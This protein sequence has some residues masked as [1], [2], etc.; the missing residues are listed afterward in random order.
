VMAGRTVRGFNRCRGKIFLSSRNR[1][2]RLCRSPSLP[3]NRHQGSSSGI[4]RPGREVDN[5]SRSSAQ[6]AE[7]CSCTYAIITYVYRTDRYN[8]TFNNGDDDDD[9]GGKYV[10]VYSN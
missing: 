9:D 3:F 5:L 6:V 10:Y 2:D 4:K 8:F 1:P 7:V